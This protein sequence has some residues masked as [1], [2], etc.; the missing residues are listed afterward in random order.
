MKSS[1][2]E[3]RRALNRTA[4]VSL[5]VALIANL[6]GCLDSHAPNGEEADFDTLA[7]DWGR[8]SCER[9]VRCDVMDAAGLDDCTVARNIEYGGYLEQAQIAGLDRDR[10]CDALVVEA[11]RDVSCDATDQELSCGLTACRAVFGDKALGEACGPS[12]DDCGQALICDSE[13]RVCVDP[14]EVT[15][16]ATSE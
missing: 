7:W 3:R 12:V 4:A 2:S 10:S 1:P 16:D 8:A 13:T 9:D 11:T 5:C 15:S 14:C 6:G